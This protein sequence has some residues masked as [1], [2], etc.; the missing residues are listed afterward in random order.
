VSFINES[1]GVLKI[2]ANP[3]GGAAGLQDK[4]QDVFK[5]RQRHIQ[6][7]IIQNAAPERGFPAAA[8]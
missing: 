3:A 8:A 6:A 7:G 1:T 5:L 4:N 2:T